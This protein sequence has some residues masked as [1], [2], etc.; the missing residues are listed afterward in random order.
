MDTH[1]LAPPRSTTPGELARDVLVVDDDHK[2]PPGSVTSG[3]ARAQAAANRRSA[4]ER[5]EAPPC[6]TYP[7]TEYP[8]S[9]VGIMTRSQGS[10]A[11]QDSQ[12][13]QPKDADAHTESG[14]KDQNRGPNRDRRSGDSGETSATR[15]NSSGGT[16]SVPGGTLPANRGGECESS[17]DGGSGQPQPSQRH[18]ETNRFGPLEV[19]ED[20]IITLPFGI[21]GFDRAQEFI[22]LDH[23]PGSMFRWL[24]STQRPDLAFVVIDPLVADPQYPLADVQKQL[25]YLDIAEGEEIIVL[26]ICTVPP[27]PAAPTVNLMAPVG[28]GLT[29]R[30]GAQV[31]LHESKYNARHEFLNAAAA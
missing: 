13:G 4:R 14:P 15:D 22:L 21:P 31:I 11:A 6:A 16:A 8:K 1:A 12:G 30:T 7:D 18:I 17:P 19:P 26:G 24:Q 27:P 25:G 3:R 28:I 10:K 23:R 9:G 2:S 5:N 29:S 20:A